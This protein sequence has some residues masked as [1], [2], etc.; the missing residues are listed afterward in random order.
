VQL[1][2]FDPATDFVVQPWISEKY[3]GQI[4]DGQ[5]V[6]GSHII[7]RLNGTIM[8]FNYEYP[9][10]ARLSPSASG[11]DTSIFM[12]MNTMRHL[13][14]LARELGFDYLA[15]NFSDG[16]VSAVLVRT[17]PAI[18]SLLIAESIQNQNEGIEVLA[19]QGI[20]SRIATAI[21]GFVRYIQI[22]S[23]ALWALAV[24]VLVAVFSGMIHERKK[25]FAILRILGATRKHL[26]SIVLCESSLASI[27]GGAA[28]ISLASIVIFP[29][30]DL[31]TMRLELPFLET[32]IV[33]IIL[34]VVIS[35]FISALVGPLAS[36]YS[37]LQVCKA[38]T[39]FTMREGE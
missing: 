17:D 8:L 5:V 19:S 7:M 11:F 29:F 26:V 32:S 28:G 15:D 33:N 34:F 3:H 23:L 14:D 39:Y 38:E 25:E 9:V 30:A 10:A 35:L 31:I 12:T 22:F 24:V 4:M 1:I 16:M 20:F 13:T 27:A 21:S 6:V 18:D 37:A 2:A 36:L